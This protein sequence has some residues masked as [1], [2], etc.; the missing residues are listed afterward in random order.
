MAAPRDFASDEIAAALGTLLRGPPRLTLASAES[1]TC[2]H[3]Q[4]AIGGV[5]GASDYFVG[6]ITAYTLA[7][8]I[9]HLGISAEAATVDAVSAEVA[10]GMAVGACRLFGSDLAVATT[11][12]A[13]PNPARSIAEPGA[14]WAVARNAGGA[15]TIVRAGFFSGPGLARREAQCAATQEVLR[16]LAGYLAVF[17]EAESRSRF[18]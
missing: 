7:Q 4:A 18:A 17:R 16:A 6:G 14:F 11:G 8:K 2:G 13:E 12:Y 3:V 1:M 5:S 10:A 15:I 9:R